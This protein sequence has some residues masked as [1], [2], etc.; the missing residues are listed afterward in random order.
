MRLFW[1]CTA[2]AVAL[3]LAVAAAYWHSSPNLLSFSGQ[4]LLSEADFWCSMGSSAL[5]FGIGILAI[6]WGVKGTRPPAGSILAGVIVWLGLTP[7]LLFGVWGPYVLFY[8][9]L[10]APTH[11]LASVG[12]FVLARRQRMEA[13]RQRFR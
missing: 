8:A 4:D 6:A 1:L 2:F 3:A 5:S 9:L 13:D 11:A 12:L 10:L 7:I